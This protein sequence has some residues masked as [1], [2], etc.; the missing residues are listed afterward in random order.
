MAVNVPGSSARLIEM[1]SIAPLSRSAI[2]CLSTPEATTTPTLHQPWHTIP[3][4]DAGRRG[5]ITRQSE[6]SQRLKCLEPICFVTPGTNGAGR[7][8]DGRHPAVVCPSIGVIVH[9]SESFEEC[10]TRTQFVKGF[11]AVS[12]L[13]SFSDKILRIS[14]EVADMG[15]FCPC[16]VDS[17]TRN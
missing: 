14:A 13:K 4:V 11:N 12:S 3:S 17:P 9:D 5:N 8:F 15:S 6:Q 2:V 10:F 7:A 1:A 16:A